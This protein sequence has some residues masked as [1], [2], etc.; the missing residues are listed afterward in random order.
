MK[1]Y[2]EDHEWV[3]LCGDE[4]LVGISEYAA[5]E[6]GDITYVALPEED[7]DFNVGDK[8]AEVESVKATSDIF[9]PI[10]GTVCE[11]NDALSDEPGLLNESPEDKGWICKLTDLADPTEINDLMNEEAYFK[12]LE[13]LKN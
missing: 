10:T 6:L 4:A 5:N 7:D 1:Y 9:S 12:Y 8:L 13:T 11:V 2:T 3:E